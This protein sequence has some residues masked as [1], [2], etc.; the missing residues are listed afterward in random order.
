MNVST[1]HGP[2]KVKAIY[3]ESSCVSSC[4]GKLEL[5]NVHGEQTAA[6]VYPHLYLVCLTANLKC[7]EIKICLIPLIW[8]LSSASLGGNSR[9]SVG[10]PACESQHFQKYDFITVAC[11]F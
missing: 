7:R 4:S 6:S 1:E 3:A 9:A 10:Q 11:F 8:L 5:G 2:L